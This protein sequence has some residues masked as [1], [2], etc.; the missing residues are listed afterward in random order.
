M[1]RTGKGQ[2]VQTATGQQ[3]GEASAQEEAQSVVPLAEMG[4]GPPPDP[5]SA[6]PRAGASP[7]ARPTERPDQPVTAPGVLAPESPVMDPQRRFKAAMLLPMLE[8]MAS[9]EMASPQLR[10]TVRKLKSFVGNPADFSDR[11]P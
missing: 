6:S 7:F 9:Q 5:S 1:P 2:K 11:N 10:N 8:Q 3:Y 4:S